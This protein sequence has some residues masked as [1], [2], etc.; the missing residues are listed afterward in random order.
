MLIIFCGKISNL[1]IPLLDDL[2]WVIENGFDKSFT[3]DAF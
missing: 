3:K 2:L 1:M